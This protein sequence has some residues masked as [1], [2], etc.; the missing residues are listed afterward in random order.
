MASAAPRQSS[1]CISD[2]KFTASTTAAKRTDVAA[3][4]ATGN[5]SRGT[6][7]SEGR[8]EQ[9]GHYAREEVSRVQEVKPGQRE[10]SRRGDDDRGKRREREAGAPLSEPE[11]RGD[12]P[13]RS[14]QASARPA[15]PAPICTA[16]T[17]PERRERVGIL[18]RDVVEPDLGN[19]LVRRG[20]R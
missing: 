5:R 2:E 14:G 8:G 16:S 13:H 20:G 12:Q 19:A 3:S 1:R 15:T 6:P 18:A 11:P 17:L 7:K 10:R 9:H 4:A